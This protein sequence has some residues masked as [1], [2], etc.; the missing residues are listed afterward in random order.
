VKRVATDISSRK[1][2][3]QETRAA[4]IQAAM[5][6]FAQ[7]GLDGPSLDAICARAGYTR[8]AF[9]V[10]FKK[11]DE[12]IVAVMERALGVFLDAVIATGHEEN[13]LATTVERFVAAIALRDQEMRT[14]STAS[15]DE[16]RALRVLE[17]PF[18]QILEACHRSVQ[19]RETFVSLLGEA[20]RRVTDAARAGQ[21]AGRV[22]DD[23]AS[24]DV[25]AL[26]I[27]MALG[28]ETAASTALPLDLDRS[29]DALIK[30][31]SS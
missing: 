15:T 24:H 12:L 28:L 8:G 2:S 5:E 17:V 23:L 4:L 13:D 9:Y 16:D 20:I 10:H 29:R 26:L 19:I 11:R 18:H 1:A 30:L 3:K 27:L 25:G 14:D 22:R 21:E 31:L 6:E 7:H